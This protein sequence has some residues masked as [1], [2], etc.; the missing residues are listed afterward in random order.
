MGKSTYS[1]DNYEQDAPKSYSLDDYEVVDEVGNAKVLKKKNG[2]EDSKNGTPPISQSKSSFSLDPVAA[3][4]SNQINPIMGGGKKT[5][6]RTSLDPLVALEETKGNA[7]LP[8]PKQEEVKSFARVGATFPD[9]GVDNTSGGAEVKA[10][11]QG[12]ASVAASTLKSIGV[13]AKDIDMFKEYGGKKAE[14]LATY[15]AGKWIEDKVKD[16]TGELSQEDQEAFSVKLAQGFGQMGGFMVGGISGKF[17]K[18]SPVLTSATLGASVGAASEYEAAIQSGATEDEASK[19]FWLNGLIGTTEALPIMSAFRKLDKYTGGIATGA[20]SRKLSSTVAGRLTNEVFQGFAE[21]ASQE[22]A[23]QFLTNVVAKN[24]YD[25]TRSLYDGVLEGAAIGGIIGAS[26]NGAVS[27]IRE[28]RLAGGLTKEEDAQLAS[29]QKFAEEKVAESIDPNKIEVTTTTNQN[30]KV[31]SIIKAKT[32]L[33]ADLAHS[34]SLPEETRVAMQLEISALNQDLEV[35]KKEAYQQDLDNNAGVLLQEKIDKNTALLEDATISEGTRGLIQKEI[36]KDTQQLES[37]NNSKPKEI[38]S[39]SSTVSSTGGLPKI[40]QLILD[41]GANNLSKESLLTVAQNPKYFID[42]MQTR[43]DNGEMQQED[44]NDKV[45]LINTAQVVNKKLPLKANGQRLNT[46]EKADYIFSRVSEAALDKKIKES[47][48]VAEQ[49]IL[50]QKIVEQQNFRKKILTNEVPITQA[51]NSQTEVTQN[52]QAQ[53]ND[54]KNAEDATNTESIVADEATVQLVKDNVGDV[55]GFIYP[56]A[57]NTADAEGI[58][59]VL[60]EASDQWHDTGSRNVAVETFGQNIIDAAIKMFP[61]QENN[62]VSVQPETELSTEV[63]TTIPTLNKE[64]EGNTEK[65]TVKTEVIN[66]KPTTVIETGN[67]F[68][69]FVEKQGDVLKINFAGIPV[70]GNRGKGFGKEGYKAILDYANKNGA[71]TVKSS[72]ALSDSA[73]NVW[74]SLS[75]EFKS[76]K[77]NENGYDREGL[78]KTKRVSKS[79]DAIFEVDVK[80]YISESIP[81]LNKEGEVVGSGVGGDVVINKNNTDKYINHLKEGGNLAPSDLIDLRYAL[82][83][84]HKEEQDV[85]Y[86]KVKEGKLSMGD[87][88]VYSKNENSE[89]RKLGIKQRQEMDLLNKQPNSF[90]L[91]GDENANETYH[92]TDANSILSVLEENHLW[93]EGETSGL[94][95]TTNKAFDHPELTQVQAYGDGN[96]P[97]TFEKGIR[98]DLDL[99][100][101]KS[102]G[103]KVKK[104]SEALGTFVGEEELRIGG[105][106]GVENASDYIKQIQVDR[107]IVD[108]KTFEEIKKAASEKGIKVVEKTDYERQRNKLKAVEQSL[109]TQEVKNEQTTAAVREPIQQNE[110]TSQEQGNKT[111]VQQSAE[112]VSGGTTETTPT[113]QRVEG[114]NSTEPVLEGG[115]S[116][117]TLSGLTENERQDIIAQR[118]KSDNASPKLID[119]QAILDAIYSYNKLPNG[120]LGKTAPVGLRAINNIRNRIATF[121]SAYNQNYKF[122]DRAGTLKGNTNKAVRTVTIDGDKQIIDG[123]VLRERSDKTKQ[124]FEDLFEAN[125]MPT[126]YTVNGT[127]MSDAQ[128]DNTVQDILDGIPSRRAISYLDNLEK[129]IEANDFDYSTSDRPL[130]SNQ[131]Q[132]TLEFILGIEPEVVGGE[133][134]EENLTAWLNDQSEFTPEQEQLVTDNFQNLITEYEQE[135]NV[136][137]VPIPATQTETRVDNQDEQ[138]VSS[139][140]ATQQNTE[141]SKSEKIADFNKKADAIANSLIDFLTPASTRGASKSGLGVEEI[142]KGAT[143]AIKAAYA[144][145]QN[146][147]EAVEAGIDYFKSNWSE[148]ELGVLPEDALRQKLT[149]DLSG[150]INTNGTEGIT[151]AATAETLSEF[152]LPEYQKTAETFTQWDEEATRRIDRGEMPI[153]LERLQKGEK[154]TAVEVR[155]MGQYVASLKRIASETKTDADIKA[156][157]DAIKLT[158]SFGTMD[159]KALVARKGLFFNGNTLADFFQE[160]M[161]ANAVDVL[162][163]QQ[164]TDIEK[165][166]ADISAAEK[167]WEAERERLNAK[168]LAM[169]AETALKKEKAKTA[170]RPATKKTHE[171]FVKDREK[172]LENIREKLKK[173]RSGTNVVIVPYANEL[174]AIAPDALKLMSSLVHEGVNKLSDVVVE[175]HRELRGVIPQITESDVRDIIAG[176]YTAKQKTKTQAAKELFDLKLEQ[177]LL[178][179]LAE[180]ESGNAPKTER[181][182]IQRNKEITELRKK[183][184]QFM[185][186][187]PSSRMEAVKSSYKTKIEELQKEL[188]NDRFPEAPKPTPPIKLDKEALEAKDRLI[189]LKNERKLRLLRTEYQNRSGT[190]KAMSV[191]ADILNVPRALMTTLDFS[192]VLRQGLI[193]SISNPIMAY[194]AGVQMFKSAWSQA[195]YDRWFYDLENSARFDLM[196]ESGLALTNND[197]PVLTVREEAFMSNLAEKIPLVGRP[198]KIGNTTIPG[199]NLIKKSERSYAAFINKMRVDL[200]HRFADAME[201]KGMDFENS[202]EQYKQMA[203]YINNATGRGSLGTA[204]N[205]ISPLLNGIFF[206]PRLIASRLNMLTYFVQPR[207]YKTVPVVVRKAYFADMAKFIG[208]GLGVLALAS[209]AGGSDDEDDKDR[210]TVE[211]DPRSSDFGKIRSGNTRWDIWGGFQPFIRVAAQVVKGERKSTQTGKIIKIDGEGAFGTDRSDVVLAFARGKLAPVPGMAV[212]LFG[213]RTAA[214]EKIIFEWNPKEKDRQISIGQYTKEHLLPLTYT[215]LE[216][217]LKEQGIKSI[218]NVGIP[219]IFGVGVQTYETK[220]TNRKQ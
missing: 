187:D 143:A 127:R 178:N 51:E 39:T 61:Q 26:M 34:T 190:E 54:S 40:S 109:P 140:E 113:V 203:E 179:R 95:T 22:A 201:G 142:V 56:N 21:E 105:R 9:A 57:I 181:A 79:S 171:D 41:G 67:G 173:A 14:D 131:E 35:A 76:I 52:T 97:T 156:M 23:Q 18:M 63:S 45:A 192:A 155:M 74:K 214:G 148:S 75:K 33:E 8:Q 119:E 72:D 30:Q 10:A 100:K 167:A 159:A 62:G 208:V 182:K 104:G 211:N 43:L 2:G 46:D 17:L 24:T 98:V 170:K 117:V 180:L 200:F 50:K 207:F 115:R 175:M 209:L 28:R 184:A 92:F 116:V 186:D 205:K 13:A 120:R 153:I 213:K 125:A 174:F 87:A 38:I 163:D 172:I 1:L 139:S 36:Q 219:S 3:I 59:N 164:K 185:R 129:Q 154:P 212:D 135:R 126:G 60:K 168:I 177:K 195:E 78:V 88:Y 189:A 96:K 106:K 11:V 94:S 81:T 89:G 198:L 166:H 199:A 162:T 82:L 7:P 133:F 217:G 65:Y 85:L 206:S 66:D 151:H 122:D 108:G 158:D 194:N 86:D 128:L 69:S 29:A 16:L 152:A 204:L 197:N 134:N 25:A 99:Q 47:N 118:R 77:E 53:S 123:V 132:T 83:E 102:D 145:S 146:I 20:L 112:P 49:E 70:E 107:K 15:K 91:E 80:S 165:E 136:A 215:G 103:I 147:Q 138:V 149:N 27:A 188:L 169:E 124:V 44:F 101:M 160:E 191:A 110:P 150:S 111:A 71:T 141:R 90:G 114:V 216:E 121:N 220:N 68:R 42:D 48:D 130:S 161:D 193:P 5:I 4:Q 157:H 183:I 37:F 12:F 58:T 176:A 218:F 84:K 144:A 55:T 202:P 73:Y 19:V 93:G 196:K 137:E 210:I 31:K 6:P 32:D 64:G